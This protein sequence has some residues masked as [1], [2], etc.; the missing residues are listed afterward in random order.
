MG[1]FDLCH[2]WSAVFHFVSGYLA[3]EKVPLVFVIVH[4]I[5]CLALFSLLY[6]FVAATPC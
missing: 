5:P 4:A 1:F 2:T 3:P 6:G